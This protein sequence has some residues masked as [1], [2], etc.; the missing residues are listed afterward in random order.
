[1][2]APA[3]SFLNLSWPELDPAGLAD[4]AVLIP[5]GQVVQHG[6]HLPVGT[7]VFQA[8]GVT[9]S[10]ASEL[11]SRGFRVLVGPTIAFGDSPVHEAFPGY[12]TLRSEVLINQFEDVASCLARQ[13][14]R[15][16]AYV[17]FGP[18]SWWALHVASA[19]LARTGAAHIL[20]IDGLQTARAVAGGLL[21][22]HDPASGKFDMHA[23]ELETSLMLALRPQLVRMDRAVTHYSELNASFAASV[24]TPGPVLQQMT[25]VGLRDWSRFGK[26]GV[27]GDAKLASADTGHQIVSRLVDNLAG[28]FVTH[29]FGERTTG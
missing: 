8:E 10:V 18:G 23:G 26:D 22:G 5:V 17:L 29:L 2:I 1:L 28:H 16:Q 24:C 14:L 20:I 3:E 6:P 19:R 7:D 15:R 21:K 25:A 27:T 13:G 4:A 12:V 9:A 11:A